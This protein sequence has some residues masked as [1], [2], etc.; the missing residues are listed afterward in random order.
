MAL[1]TCPDCGKQLSDQAASCIQCGRPM[2][3]DLVDKPS[4]GSADA[5]KVGRQ[6]SKLRNDTGHAIAFIGLPIALVVGMASSAWIGW[7][8][9]MVVFA[10][11]I[12][13]TYGS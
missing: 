9:A 3:P 7:V 1:I 12:W 8:L 4:A 5:A 13:V 2:K 11:A 6:R 10:L